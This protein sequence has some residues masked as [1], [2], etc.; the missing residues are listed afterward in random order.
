MTDRFNVAETDRCMCGARRFTVR[1]AS[2]PEYVHQAHV[3]LLDRH[4]SADRAVRDL[5]Q[6]ERETHQPSGPESEP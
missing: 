5:L 1:D 4:N 2:D 3:G 6:A